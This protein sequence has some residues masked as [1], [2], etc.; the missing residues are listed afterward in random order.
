MPASGQSHS[1]GFSL[2]TELV[3]ALPILCRYAGRIGAETFFQRAVGTGDGRTRLS[4]AKAL[5][6]ATMNICVHHE[7]VYALGEW[8]GRRDPALLGLED[9]DVAYLNDDRVGRALARLFDADRATLLGELVLRAVAAFDIDCSRLHN[10]STSVKLQG[11]YASATG[12]RRGTKKTVAAAYGFSKDHRPDLK[13]LVWILTVAADGAVP[14]LHR[15]VDGNTEDSTT[16]IAT[17]DALCALLGRNDF[18]YVADA[19]LAVRQTMSHIDRLGGR[20]VSVL[21]RNRKEDEAMRD[22]FVAHEPVWKQAL[23]LPGRR[24]DD[25]PDVYSVCDAPWPSSEGYRVIWVR[26]S[27]KVERDEEARRARIASGIAA[28]DAINV[29]LSSPRTRLKS[30]VAIGLEAD[31]ALEECGAARWVGY[32]I[33]EVRE[34]RHRQES[35][36]RPGKNTRYRRI[37][38]IRHRLRFSVRDDLVA[39]D[40]A[41]DG[42]WPLVTNVADMEAEELLVAYK[43][44]PHLERRHHLLKGDQLVAPV[45]LQ[46]PARIEGLM[47][48]HFLALLLQALMELEVRRAMANRHIDSLALYPEERPSTSPSAQRMIEVFTGVARHR[49]FDADGNLVQ[50]FAPVLTPLQEQLLDL[51]GVPAGVYA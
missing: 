7:P 32:E 45:F 14:L 5:W 19:K 4:P 37:E 49:L 46:D 50:T 48:C 3:E 13:Q 2:E 1:G 26:S 10:D 38:K 11:V 23:V 35:R 6:V 8:A 44:Q 20:F 15:V 16:H 30:T 24:G 17:W 33:E 36:G 29:R 28:L 25:E 34:V 47:T 42:C 21:P 31:E 12:G 22:W 27:A 51:L 41:S 9:N 39:H 43:Y 18:L 40:A